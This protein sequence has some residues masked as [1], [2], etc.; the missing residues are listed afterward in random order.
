[1]APV[2]D[3][4]RSSAIADLEARNTDIIARLQEIQTEFE[5][6]AFTDPAKTEWNALNEE[7]EQNG[8]LI[9]ELRARDERLAAVAGR[10]ENQE[11]AGPQ[12][13]TARPGAVRGGDIYD[14]TTLRVGAPQ[15]MAV[16]LRDRAMRSV[17]VA[18]FPDAVRSEDA[19]AHIAKLI[20]RLDDPERQDGVPG[21]VSRR[22]LT[23]GS[24]LY[25]R[26]FAKYMGRGGLTAD[27]QRAL[28][29]GT[30]SAG[31]FALVYTLDPTIVP[32]SNLSVNP[33]RE[34][35]S[36]ETIAGTNEWRGVTS[37]GVTAAYVAELTEATDSSPALAQPA[38]QVAKAHCFVPVSIELTQD[39]GSIQ[40]DLSTLITDAKDDLEA[41]SFTTG[42]YSA[43]ASPGGIITGATNTTTAAGTAS[44]A[45]ADLYTLWQ[46]LPPRFRPRA[47]FL[48]NLYAYNKIRQ[49]DTAG[50]ASL[51][52]QNL[53]QGLNTN[54]G[55]TTQGTVGA[56]LLAKPAYEAT[57]M[58]SAVTTGSKLVLVGDGRYFKIID[59][60]GMDI[61]VIQTLFGTNQRPT[62][63]RGFYAYWRNTSK[64]LDANAFRVL[65][66]G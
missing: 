2:I 31:G 4:P 11:Q 61:E 8:V 46:S 21:E 62:G 14:L 34:F 17:D 16:E 38:L 53:T 60:V 24:P 18:S 6:R 63:S 27:E 12:F 13:Q 65:V 55:P 49:F 25:K 7:I 64:V 22:V 3:P 43:G 47:A 26:A 58:A 42:T 33:Y 41:T 59:R 5:A 28:S 29:V 36:V 56:T 9:G 30:G 19:K 48:A 1:M 52:V 15:E 57:A 45:V 35:C 44:F 20:E 54:P 37:A 39:W 66:T 50:G 10:T 40:S 23:T 51:W 32:T